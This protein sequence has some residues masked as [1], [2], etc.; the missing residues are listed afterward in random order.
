MK[1]TAVITLTIWLAALAGVVAFAYLSTRPSWNQLTER[2]M[3]A[4]ALVAAEPA[5]SVAV[6][7]PLSAF[8]RER[9]TQGLASLQTSLEAY[10]GHLLNAEN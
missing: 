1:G 7:A 10:Q 2:M 4:P 6:A 3:H 5:P 9:L 8:D